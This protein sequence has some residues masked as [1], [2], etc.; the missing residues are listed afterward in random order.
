MSF[1]LPAVVLAAAVLL[2]G[3]SRTGFFADVIVQLLGILLLLVC[4]WRWTGRGEDTSPRI[5]SIPFPLWL[6]G[7][8]LLCLLFVQLVPMPPS[9]TLRWFTAN[10]LSPE[11]GGVVTDESW[12][13][14]SLTPEPTRAA[15]ASVIPPIA[16]FASIS[17]MGLPA[18]FR[19][20]ALVIGLSAVALIL[21]FLQVAQGPQSSLRFFQFT[22]PTEAV[23]FFANRNHFA[24]QLYTALVFAA[25]WF[26]SATKNFIRRGTLDTRAILWFAAA[27]VLLIATI[28]GLALA[29][30]RAG[31]ILA[32][33][34]IGGIA[35]IFF[36]DGRAADGERR[37]S[38]RF[39]RRLTL[40]A[41]VIAVLFA[42]QFGLHRVM[43][44]FEADPLSDLRTALTPATLSAAW[45][46][47]PFGTG[48]GSFIRVYSIKEKT[49]DLFSGH[50]NRAHNDWA[51]LL[52]ETGIFG[53]ALAALF[54][55]WFSSRAIAIWR[56]GPGERRDDDLTLQRAATVVIVLLLAHSLVD[57]PLRT[58]AMASVFALAC[59]LLITPPLT[60]T[61]PKAAQKRP[62]R[63]RKEPSAPMAAMPTGAA[64]AAGMDL[65]EAWE[66]RNT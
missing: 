34:A 35:T 55:W 30:S 37:S 43:T 3:G 20:A 22:N 49:T 16:L 39:A 19:M 50:A 29:R 27:A 60:E 33:F 47:L 66:R 38:N 18:R 57:Y 40:A 64:T 11:A 17:Q 46:S 1:G 65:A 7:A 44:R 12:R 45:E 23:G 36:D 59:A 54:L 42:T 31:L 6:A 9:L 58:T 25:V 5:R 8:L 24:A 21:G 51:E 52:L 62:S 32:M 14:L 41:L 63:R 13:S 26:F 28:A 2:G 53:V 10:G 4:L 48:F 61:P 56:P 15:I